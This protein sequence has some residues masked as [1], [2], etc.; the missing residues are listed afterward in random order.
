M[1]GQHAFGNYRNLL[2]AV[3]Y[4]PM[5]GLYLSHLRN[6]KENP[7]TGAVPDENYAR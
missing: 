5:M 4:S 2:E 1:L 6:Q 3:T 7:A